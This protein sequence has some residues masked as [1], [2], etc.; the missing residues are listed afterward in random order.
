MS[1]SAGERKLLQRI[2]MVLEA[3]VKGI[4]KETERAICL[5]RI[6]ALSTHIDNN[7]VRQKPLKKD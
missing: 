2:R 3:S 6:N 4:D 5:T 7:A 1:A